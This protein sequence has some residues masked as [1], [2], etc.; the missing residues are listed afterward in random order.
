VSRRAASRLAW[1]TVALTVL[2]TAA[3]A[4]IQLTNP[5]GAG[6]LYP[7][8]PGFVEAFAV[9]AVGG[10]VG[11]L[12]I[13]RHPGNAVGWIFCGAGLVVALTA[14][15]LHYSGRALL[16]APGSLPAGHEANWLVVLVQMGW[17]A[18]FTFLPLLFPDGRLPSRRWRPVAWASGLVLAGLA[19]VLTA[20]KGRPSEAV[21]GQSA[22]P[23]RLFA[24]ALTVLGAALLGLVLACAVALLLRLRRA[25]GDER[26]QLRWFV[27]A[28]ALLAVAATLHAAGT[29]LYGEAQPW[30]ETAV[31][32]GGAAVPV[33]A[34]VAIFKYRLYDIDLI[35]N[36]AIVLLALAGFITGGYVLVVAGLGQVLG[37]RWASSDWVA[38]VATAVVALAFQP[39]RRRLQRLADQ[40]IYGPRAAPYEVLA[41]FS[42]R[43]A[44][45]LQPEEVLPRM[46]EA[47]A[48]GVGA[49]RSQITLLLA[50]GQQVVS[51][52]PDA[53]P[54]G[55]PDRTV[56]V[57][58]R[59]EPVGEL[60]VAMPPGRALT[61]A[62][63]RLLDDLATQAGLAL[64]NARLTIELQA[65][66]DLLAAQ[67]AEL[68]ASRTRLI[69]AQDQERQRLER[70]IRQG[71]NQQLASIT[72]KL[73]QAER[74]VGGDPQAT[75]ALLDA[76]DSEAELAADALR[77]L[78]RGLFPSLLADKGLL[79]AISALVRKAVPTATVEASSAAAGRWPPHV[80]A[81][82]YF[83]CQE[84]LDNAAHHAAGAPVSVRLDV[85]SGWLEFSVTDSGPGF[86]V[87]AVDGTGLQHMTDR[88][89][90]LAGTLQVSSAPTLGTQVSGRIPLQATITEANQPPVAVAATAADR[91]PSEVQREQ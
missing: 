10:A 88:V 2:L 80:E 6:E 91:A 13:S 74:T 44:G 37:G 45:A 66:L 28:V 17:G 76:L 15:G 77:D 35:I 81:A 30:G 51:W 16:V 38:L 11:A 25:R 59:G 64:H 36:R 78:A 58:H 71:P 84:A 33:A 1:T 39:V 70:A 89:E 42:D 60:A 52:P 50:E 49:A 65:R 75:A 14:F 18:L 47:A 73:R 83:C 53:P 32:L 7:Q 57:L 54:D 4:A 12:I 55:P 82:A 68:A 63:D 72:G 9:G 8:F 87:A 34:G 22:P 69:Q 61:R 79:A 20:G 31:A 27:T 5:P 67:A 19:V 21:P 85:Q 40:L 26:R 46:A 24:V 86:D 56:Q 62:E 90:A 29:F 43:I 3:C 41:R 23:N 48:Q